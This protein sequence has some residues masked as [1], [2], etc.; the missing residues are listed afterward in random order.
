MGRGKEDVRQDGAFPRSF[1]EHE[2]LTRLTCTQ[3]SIARSLSRSVWVNIGAPPP[4]KPAGADTSLKPPSS[5][6]EEGVTA[7]VLDEKVKVL[8]LIV[9]FVVATKHHVRREYGVD[10]PGTSP[11]PAS[12]SLALTDTPSIR[13]RA[14]SCTYR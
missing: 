2:R 5:T 10:W 12:F 4:V 11:V 1:C 14:H 3:S 8:R 13:L 6:V 9:A 7:K